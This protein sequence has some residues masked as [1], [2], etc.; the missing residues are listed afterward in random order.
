MPRTNDCAMDTVPSGRIITRLLGLPVVDRTRRCRPV[1]R[2]AGL[3]PEDASRSRWLNLYAATSDV[4]RNDAYDL[5]IFESAGL[6]L[7]AVPHPCPECGV[8]LAERGGW[9]HLFDAVPRWPRDHVAIL[10]H[11]RVAGPD[12]PASH[13]T[14]EIDNDGWVLRHAECAV[15]RAALD[16]LFGTG[17]LLNLTRLAQLDNGDETSFWR[18][19]LALAAAE[20]T[21]HVIG[22]FYNRIRAEA[23]RHAWATDA[24]NW[25]EVRVNSVA[26]GTV[27]PPGAS[28]AVLGLQVRAAALLE[29]DNA[30]PIGRLPASQSPAGRRIPSPRNTDDVPGARTPIAI[31]IAQTMEARYRALLGGYRSTQSPAPFSGYARSPDAIDTDEEEA[32]DD[33]SSDVDDFDDEHVTFDEMIAAVDAG[34]VDTVS[35]FFGAVTS[36]PTEIRDPYTDTVLATTE[37]LL[38]RAVRAGSIDVVSLFVNRD[39]PY[40]DS[41]MRLA[42]VGDNWR[43]LQ[44]VYEEAPPGYAAAHR[45]AALTAAIDAVAVGGVRYLLEQ[46]TVTRD[47]LSRALNIARTRPSDDRV[48]QIVKLLVGGGQ[49]PVTPL[50]QNLARDALPMRYKQLLGVLGLPRS[51]ARLAG[52]VYADEGTPEAAAADAAIDDHDYSTVRT[53]V[54]DH[55]TLDA[56][57][58]DWFRSARDDNVIWTQIQLATGIEYKAERRMKDGR[59]M[60]ALD[61]AAVSNAPRVIAAIRYYDREYYSSERAKLERYAR[62]AMLER[63]GRGNR[64]Y[65][66]L[67]DH[68]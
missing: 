16:F 41:L 35:L 21:L 25:F 65:L 62:M 27:F 12:A 61:I 5:L 53:G 33:E 24:R 60:S 11:R 40:A 17:P 6:N 39:V 3:L 49:H 38:V 43:V 15:R 36:Y 32:S 26:L 28:E 45:G 14:P 42:A 50:M 56:W 52:R 58:R 19:M 68:D 31:G 22:T 9:T 8:P 29:Q 18:F 66:Y 59:R 64:A 44:L 46:G 10:A 47:A 48:F 20:P 4:Q 37:E 51:S 57:M 34:E 7:R 55:R 30:V 13:D 2:S 23:T 1:P 63:Q 67:R 54:P